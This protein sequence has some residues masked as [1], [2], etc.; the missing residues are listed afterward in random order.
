M[1]NELLEFYAQYK[2][3]SNAYSLA[4][5]IMHFDQSTIAPTKGN[6]HSNQMM[7]VLS[8][9]AFLHSTNKE[10]IQKIEQLSTLDIEPL[11]KKEI[12]RTLKHLNQ[13]KHVPQD[14]FTRNTIAVNAAST[15]WGQ[16]KIDQDYNRFKPYLQS[17]VESTKE[18]L[19]YHPDIQKGAYAILL[20]QFEPGMTVEKYDAFFD[21]VKKGLVP[22][23]HEIIEKGTPIDE[24]ILEQKFDIKAQENFANE[25]CNYLKV[26]PEVCYMSTSH[27]PFTTFLSNHDVRMTTHYYEDILLSSIYSVIH[28]YGHALFGLQID[29]KFEGSILARDIGSA[30]HESQSRFLENHIGKSTA[31]WKANIENLKRHFPQLEQLSIDE[32]M[33]LINASKPS[34]IRTEADELTYPLHVLIRY[35]LEKEMFS[36]DDID[37]DAL[38]QRWNDLYKQYL[39]VTPSHDGVGILQDMHWSSA[40]FGYFP[41]YALGSAYAAQFFNTMKQELDVDYLLENN[42]FDVISNWLKEKIHHYGGSKSA[43]DILLEVTK[44]AFNPKYYIDYLQ[45]K[46]RTLYNL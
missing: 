12:E 7:S 31:F 13:S 11:L 32:L 20:D 35:E 10:S 2:E 14:V 17:V 41:T 38:K 8:T 28:E 4:L 36:R 5:T 22:L 29:S 19:Q 23:I 9:E 34:L 3:K 16:A 30:M 24:S 6:A 42:Q 44:E 26:D 45:Q 25:L 27:H 21:E 18:T 37:Y 39:G 1:K 33:Q 40:Y 15:T 43:Q 46:Y